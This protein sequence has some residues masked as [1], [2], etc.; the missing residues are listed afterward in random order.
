MQFIEF[1][2]ED[3]FNA[4]MVDDRRVAMSAERDRVVDQTQVLRVDLVE[5]LPGL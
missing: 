2:S 3:A 4:Y 5:P 1:P